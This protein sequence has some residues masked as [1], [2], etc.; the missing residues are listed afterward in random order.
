MAYNKFNVFHWHIVDDQSFPFES[1]LYPNLTRLVSPVG[2]HFSSGYKLNV[3]AVIALL[4]AAYSPSHVYSQEDIRRVIR[5]ARLRGIRVIPEIDTPGHTQGFGKAFPGA[6]LPP[7]HLWTR[8][9]RDYAY[10]R[11]TRQS[12]GSRVRR[13]IH[14]CSPMLIL[15]TIAPPPVLPETCFPSNE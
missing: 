1:K 4:Q 6:S 14:L 11:P 7:I 15:L 3:S 12:F 13:T 8:E 9:T 5:A 2:Q 10:M